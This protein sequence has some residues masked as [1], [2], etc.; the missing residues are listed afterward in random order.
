ME[1]KKLKELVTDRIS[2]LK[3]K[4]ERPNQK[5]LNDPAVKDCLRIN[6]MK[7]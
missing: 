7:I 1:G 4:F 2:G 6:S 3:G 5:I